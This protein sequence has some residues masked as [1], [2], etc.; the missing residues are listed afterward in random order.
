MRRIFFVVILFSLFFQAKAQYH[1]L[2]QLLLP[3]EKYNKKRAALV[4]TTMAS[5]FT[6]TMFGLKSAWYAN[7]DRSK[8]HF[9]N[10]NNEWLQCDKV[11]H[12]AWSYYGAYVAGQAYK[13][14]GMP[15]KKAAIYGAGV[16]LGMTL[17]VEVLDGFS[18]KWGF[19]NGDLIADIG[20]AGLYLAQELAW[21]QQ[22]VLLKYSSH[23]THYT[24]MALEKRAD[25]LFGKG[26]LYRMVKDYNGMTFWLSANIHD[27]LPMNNKVPKWLNIAIGYGA[28][29]MFNGADS[30]KYAPKGIWYSPEGKRVYGTP[31]PNDYL[32]NQARYRQF[33]LS[34]DLDLSKVHTKY[35]WLNT[36]CKTVNVIKFPAPALEYNTTRQWKFHSLYF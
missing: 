5:G 2:N 1:L 27:F 20:G 7:Y 18:N 28:A 30:L 33:Y 25:D 35:N 36:L 26:V 13:W 9:F 31:S 17:I 23:N 15:Y 29:N 21:K 12:F 34:L 32:F 16:G 24:P 22:R 6:A 4:H 19:S 11:G 14:T 8:F 10:D 3:E